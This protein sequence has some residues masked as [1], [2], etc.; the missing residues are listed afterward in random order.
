MV[1]R[2]IRWNMETDTGDQTRSRHRYIVAILN[3]PREI[4]RIKQRFIEQ[5]RPYEFRDISDYLIPNSN[6]LHCV[7][8]SFSSEK[9]E[10]EYPNKIYKN[11]AQ[12]R[13]DRDLS[14]RDEQSL[15]P[16]IE[17]LVA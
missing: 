3:E 6:G 4:Q 8:F 10:I 2:K 15:F 16:Y 17:K 1:E 11:R 14:D 13:R 12:F 5:M 7:A 9:G